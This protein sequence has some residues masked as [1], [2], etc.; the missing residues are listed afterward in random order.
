[1]IQRIQSVYL[2]IAAIAAM[3]VLFLPLAIIKATE[4]TAKDPIIATEYVP[5]MIIG[6][7]MVTF[8]LGAVFLY[9][10]RIVQ[11]KVGW[12]GIAAGMAFVAFFANLH[13]DDFS[14][15]QFTAGS[16]MPILFLIMLFLAIRSINKDH[17]L[18]KSADRFR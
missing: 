6:F 2:F 7:L 18:V 11:M 13:G 15:M 16:G 8:S 5:L 10:N 3:L 12:V 4:E 17:K 14:N 9:A 1:M